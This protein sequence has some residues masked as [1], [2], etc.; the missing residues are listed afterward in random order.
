MKVFFAKNEI[1]RVL[2]KIEKL[3]EKYRQYE[4]RKNRVGMRYCLSEIK[5]LQVELDENYEI[6]ENNQEL[7]FSL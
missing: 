1:K 3:R 7:F 5:K 6:M 2:S 4:L